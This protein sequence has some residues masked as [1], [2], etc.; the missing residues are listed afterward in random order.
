[1]PPPRTP[2]PDAEAVV[3]AE[4]TPAT[5]AAPA[6][7]RLT[8]RRPSPLRP[9]VWA[10]HLS[11]PVLGLWLLI[12]EPGADVRWEHHDAH[13]ALVLSTAVIAASIG[14]LIAGAA[15]R[16]DDARI[17]L[18]A[19]A[20]LASAGFFAVHAL[21]TPMVLIDVTNLGWTASTTVGLLVASV[22][23]LLSA[24]DLPRSAGAWPLRH[25][26]VILTA[27]DGCARRVDALLPRPVP[28]VRPDRA[29][30]RG[31]R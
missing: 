25:A 11:L 8:V 10:L 17:F 12:E 26:L 5:A 9:A 19:C 29:P 14:V 30:R 23:A 27:L 20:F 6:P 31:A 2:V 21:T 24:F 28:A 1:M 13:F 15:R 7:P 16:H 3:E 18:V 4:R 22:F